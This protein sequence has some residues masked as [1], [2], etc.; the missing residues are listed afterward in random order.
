M[1]ALPRKTQQIF[2]GSA[3]PS[4]NLAV[5]ASLAQGAPAYSDD[6]AVIQSAQWLQGLTAALVGNHSIAQEDLN[7][8]L[9]VL[10]QQLAYLF[11]GGL[12]EYDANTTYWKNQL[13]RL[14]GAQF[15]AASLT[16]NNTGHDPAS[17]SNNW[18]TTALSA[19]V[20][21]S[22]SS[23]Q[24]VAM[25]GAE[26]KIAFAATGWNPRTY[27]D[28]ANNW[29]VAPAKGLYQVA[30]TIQLDNNGAP[31]NIEGFLR[32][33]IDGSV[34]Y[35]WPQ[36]WGGAQNDGA[37]WYPHLAGAVPLNAG[38]KLSLSIGSL[39]NVGGSVNLSN[40]FLSIARLP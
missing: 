39:T 19:A 23:T 14:T 8:I 5:Y 12:P 22:T 9:F 18:D 37:R 2:A 25:D 6:P 4:G 27:W 7:G 32:A 1:P 30:A 28:T 3:V 36:G 15:L 20:Q 10:T 17:D 11:Q 31:T 38:D 34:G 33:K 21:V 40:S 16:D 35:L 13:A 29:Y 24:A 26:H